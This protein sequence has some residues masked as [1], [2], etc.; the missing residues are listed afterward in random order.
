MKFQVLLGSTAAALLIHSVATVDILTES[1][2]DSFTPNSFVNNQFYT[3]IKM[4]ANTWTPM[5]LH[6]NPFRKW[7]DK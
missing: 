3:E 4:N 5:D 6:S 1:A 2:D 7:S